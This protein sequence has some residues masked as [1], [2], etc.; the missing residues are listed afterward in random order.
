M[1]RT[2]FLLVAL[3]LGALPARA[4]VLAPEYPEL[5]VY[6]L[7]MG[8][9]DQVWERFGHNALWIRDRANGTERVYNY[10]VFDF[11]SPG[12]WS[13]FVR[14]NWLYQL[15]ASDIYSTVA[16]YEWLNRTLVA[17][18]LDLTTDQRRELQQFL[19]W[20]AR[21][22]NREYRY[23]YFRDNCS[24]RIRDAL[25]R[26]LGGSLRAATEDLPSGTTYRWHSRRMIADD[27][28]AYVGMNIGLGP[29]AD[30]PISVWEEMFLPEK[31]LEQA[32]RHRIAG[33]DGADRPLLASEHV[34]YQAVA[35][36]PE[37]AEPPV[38]WPV[39]L[40]VGLALAGALL[41]L[42]TRAS[43]SGAARL[44]FSVGSALWT[45]LT[46][47][48][49]VVLF[50]LWAFTDH[51]FA[52]RNENLLQFNPLALGLVLLLPALAYG[53]RWARRPALLLALTVAGMSLLGVVLQILP[54]FYQAN[55]E[56][57]AVAV[58]VHLALAW[59]VYRLAGEPAAVAEPPAP[60]RERKPRGRVRVAAP[61]RPSRR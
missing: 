8:Q 15:D 48:G 27:R 35:R 44:G 34:L 16:Q 52:H 61:D 57:L 53:A 9:G 49:G 56:A 28:P 7:T 51:D 22:E 5:E 47:T 1:Y 42:G 26:V 46:G 17:H 10:G 45:L 60:A 2:L 41:L 33:P 38:R 14:G 20:N 37:R 31:L 21:P 25:D 39:F 24:T 58:P 32:R 19:E 3:V 55:L 36:E 13:R 11:N 43:R 18:E 6:L 4:Q 40:L 54:W 30:R 50:A 29:A 12:Y 59:V 23:D